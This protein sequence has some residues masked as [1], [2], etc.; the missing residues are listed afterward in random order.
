MAENTPIKLNKN[1]GGKEFKNSFRFIGLVRPVRKKNQATDS[2][3]ALPFYEE[4]LTQTN[5]PRRVLQFNVETAYRNELKVEVAGMEKDLAY[6]WSSKHRKSTSVA[7]ADRKNKEVLPDE[8]YHVMTTEWDLT[9]EVGAWLQEDM[10]VD[11][12]GS[13]EFGSFANEDGETVNTVKRIIE[14]VYPLKNGEVEI[15]GLKEGDEFKAFD[16]ATDGRQLGYGKANKDGV[17]NIKVGWLNPNGGTLYVTKLDNGKETARTKL[18]YTDGTVET[19]RVVVKNNTDSTIAVP[20]TEKGK[21]REYITYVR[22]FKSPNFVEINT[23][24]M[25]LGIRSTYQEES[26]DTVVN[27]VYLSYGKERSAVND[28]QLKVYY[29]E[30]EEGKQAFADAFANLNRLDFLKVKGID[31]NRAEFAMVEVAD[32]SEDNPFENVGEKETNYEQVSTGTK[33]GLEILSYLQGTFQRELLKEE[34]ITPI[35]DNSVS[36]KTDDPFATT[37]INADDLPF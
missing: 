32:T 7:W 4:K 20:S 8:T 31:N 14:S 36:V 9:E 6:A 27:G 13:Y 30:P 24:E 15:K 16:S 26:K 34:E 2:W 1:H 22:D 3:D 18:D 21:K 25:Q 12:K 10:W 29:K 17:V 11:V 35:E 28:V 19:D 33:K 37:V 5:K 23:F